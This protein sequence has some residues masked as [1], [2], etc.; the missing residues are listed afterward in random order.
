MSE[1]AFEKYAIKGA[2]HWVEY[3]GPVHR[4]N[5]YTRARYRNVVAALAAHNLSVGAPVLDVGCG[6]GALSG[7][8]VQKLQVAITGIDTVAQS[9]E[10]AKQEFGKRNLQGQFRLIDG[11]V[12]PFKD[13]AFSAVI[14]SEVIEHVREPEL[15]LREM[16]RLVAPGGILVVTTPVRYTEDPLDRMHVQEWFPNAFRK[17]CAGTLGAQV[18]LKLTHPVA[19]AE[20]YASPT[21]VFGRAFRLSMN[22]LSKCGLEPFGWDRGFRA[23]STQMITARKA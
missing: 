2:Y 1:I 19:F 3:F 15:M 8:I 9:I 17:F 12:Y 6:D 11:Y 10:L 4:I 18:D 21:P 22:V 23:Y 20:F 5:A 13:E 16:W 7:L 14:C